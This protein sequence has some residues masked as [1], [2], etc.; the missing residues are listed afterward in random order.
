[1][2]WGEKLVFIR[3]KRVCEKYHLT[4]EELKTL[5]LQYEKTTPLNLFT[6]EDGMCIDEEQML[7]ILKIKDKLIREANA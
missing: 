4:K 2:A 5:L 6:V 1:M 7:A 3:F